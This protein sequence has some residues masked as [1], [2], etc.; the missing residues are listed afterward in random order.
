MYPKVVPVAVKQP[1][2][3]L[4]VHNFGPDNLRNSLQLSGNAVQR[5]KPATSL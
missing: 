1:V 3:G 5:P 2:M 4:A